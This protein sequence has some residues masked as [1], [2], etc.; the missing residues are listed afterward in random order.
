MHKNIPSANTTNGQV[1]VYLCIYGV[2]FRLHIKELSNFSN[3]FIACASILSK[4][5][6]Y[7]GLAYNE[8]NLNF[9][10]VNNL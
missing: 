5:G 7:I 4:T 1:N 10:S 8:V 6:L 2:Y 9:L 3:S